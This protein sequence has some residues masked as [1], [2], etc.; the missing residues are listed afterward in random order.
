MSGNVEDVIA[1]N[2]Q[3]GTVRVFARNEPPSEAEAIIE[4]AV[5]RRG[6]DVEFF[7]SAPC[8]RYN[9]GDQ[10]APEELEAE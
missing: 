10:Y 5:V 3:S 9:D 4:M 6:C 2:I 8:G 7:T 1:V